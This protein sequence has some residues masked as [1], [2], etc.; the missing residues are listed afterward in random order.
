MEDLFTSPSALI[1]L[2]TGTYFP[3]IKENLEALLKEGVLSN[4]VVISS[5]KDQLELIKDPFIPIHVSSKAKRDGSFM[6]RVIE[7]HNGELQPQDIIVLGASESDFFMSVN[8]KTLMLTALYAKNNNPKGRI[9]KYG[10]PINDPDHLLSFMRKY[11]KISPNCYYELEVDKQTKI[12]A[13][14]SA[15]YFYSHDE[16]LKQIKRSIESFLKKNNPTHRKDYLYYFLLCAYNK[17]GDLR[18]IDYWG[19]YPSSHKKTWNQ[20]LISFKEEVRK[21]FKTRDQPELLI[22]HVD[23]PKRHHMNKD[24]RIT[25][26]CDT[27]FQSIILN[28]HYKGKLK[29]KTICIF[30]DFNTYGSSCETTRILLQKEGIKKLIFITMGKFG[31][32][33]IKTDYSIEG[34]VFSKYSA[35]NNDKQTYLA[36]DFYYDADKELS[37]IFK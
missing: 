26:G 37:K 20:D 27:Q 31:K 32:E 15:N 13:I 12:Y 5:H 21:V 18:N 9:F 35:T 23:A 14:N 7:I 24:R 19:I 34:D 16:K 22:R 30:D 36:G 3:K 8:S 11:L 28:P 25:D 4:V 17:I 29:D 2:K 1:D 33:Y 6:K 10:V